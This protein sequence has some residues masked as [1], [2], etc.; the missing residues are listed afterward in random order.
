MTVSEQVKVLCVRCN[1]SEAELARLLGKSPQSLNAKLKRGTM[2]VEELER[3]AVVLG[4]DFKRVFILG[5][6]DE[7]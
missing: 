7:I 4:V 1:V 5:N 2:T 3:I 6:G